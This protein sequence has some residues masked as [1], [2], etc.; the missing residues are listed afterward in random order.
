M[1]LLETYFLSEN[2]NSPL[3]TAAQD[4][5]RVEIPNK[6]WLTAA[7]GV[8]PVLILCQHSIPNVPCSLD[9][10]IVSDLLVGCFDPPLVSD[11]NQF[12]SFTGAYNQAADPY[13]HHGR[14]SV[15]SRYYPLPSPNALTTQMAI[16]LLIQHL[17]QFD[18]DDRIMREEIESLLQDAQLE[19]S[20]GYQHSHVLAQSNLLTHVQLPVLANLAAV[21]SKG[22]VKVVTSP[23]SLDNAIMRGLKFIMDIIKHN[24]N[25]FPKVPMP[26]YIFMLSTSQKKAPEFCFLVSGIHQA[27][28]L[29][30]AMLGH[31]VGAR[32][33]DNLAKLEQLFR[34]SSDALEQMVNSYEEAMGHAQ[35]IFIPF[36]G[37]ARMK[38]MEEEVLK[39]EPKVT[40][41]SFQHYGQKTNVVYSTQNQIAKQLVAQ[42]CSIAE[43]SNA[44]DINKFI[45]IDLAVVVP[46]IAT[47]FNQTIQ[48]LANSGVL[49]DLD[50]EEG[51]ES[52]GFEASFNYVIKH[53]D[54]DTTQEKLA[55]F[56]KKVQTQP[57]TLF[58]LIFDQAQFYSSPRGVLDLPFYKEFLEASNV[59]PL[60][61]TS[62]PYLFQTNCSFIDPENEVY[63]ADSKSDSGKE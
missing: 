59:I 4:S 6:P 57:S 33:T 55:K 52:S 45:K 62:A 37:F 58:I 14:G 35:L 40:M 32:I 39:M 1:I 44:L 8:C 47:L 21:S 5:S 22:R 7:C 18:E 36:N 26:D 50:L 43:N 51:K 34:L 24:Q 12:G 54:S 16:L 46:P 56:L 25:K 23:V 48:K 27:R 3:S 53:D 61:V 29:T 60:F 38:V 63:W 10:I 15:G 19:L 9:D 13:S 42:V 30:E 28:Y 2:E 31:P 49:A 17:S 41:T 20:A 11:H